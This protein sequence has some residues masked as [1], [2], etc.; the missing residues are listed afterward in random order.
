MRSADAVRYGVGSEIRL[1]NLGPMAF[2]GIINC[3]LIGE[4]VW[5]VLIVSLYLN[6]TDHKNQIMDT[7][8]CH[9]ALS[10]GVERSRKNPIDQLV[11]AKK[12]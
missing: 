5:E 4:N 2:S 6:W 8:I 9:L 1:V 7:R 10:V 11:F 12:H 3:Q